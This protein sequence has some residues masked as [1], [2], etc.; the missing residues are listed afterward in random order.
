MVDCDYDEMIDS[1][2][3]QIVGA[4]N[5][6]S[7]NSMKICV[8]VRKRPMF[9]KET[10]MGEIDAVSCANPKILVHEPK[11]RVDGITKYI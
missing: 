10:A 8:C 11:I 1:E 4:F 5:H 7:S 6:V 2:R 3:A 9:D